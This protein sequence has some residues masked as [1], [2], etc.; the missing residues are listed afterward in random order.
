MKRIFIFLLLVTISVLIT[1]SCGLVCKHEYS[2]PSCVE[3][4]MCQKCGKTKGEALGHT[5]LKATCNKPKTCSTCNETEGF[6]NG[7]DWI[8]ATCETKKQCAVCG[9]TRGVP[10]GHTGGTATCTSCAICSRCNQEYGAFSTHH[11]MQ[12]VISDEYF[13]APATCTKADT[14]FYSCTCGKKSD[15]TFTFGN[16]LEHIPGEW[17]EDEPDYVTATIW[18]RRNC[19]V[20]G[21]QTDSSCS[22]ITSLYKNK[23]FLFSPNEFCD[24][25][26]GQFANIYDVSGKLYSAKTTNSVSDTVSVGITN[27]GKVVAIIM[28]SGTKNLLVPS[29]IDKNNCISVMM[30]QDYTTSSNVSDFAF[31]LVAVLRSCDPQLTY[32]DTTDII[33]EISS[34]SYSHKYHGVSYAMA[35]YNGSLKFVVSLLK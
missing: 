20:C 30:M 12:Q 29:D 1:S 11:Y 4:S 34:G 14:Y 31:V 5:W 24:R 21:N 26:N 22:D 6:S 27:N 35:E 2:V 19:T 17:T 28:F 33:K 8:K 13:C 23:H 9:E 7:H 15:Q 25:L 3:V 10:L 18:K 32:S 16:P